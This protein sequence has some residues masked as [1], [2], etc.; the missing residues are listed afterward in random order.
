MSLH[1]SKGHYTSIVAFSTP[2]GRLHIGHA[3]GQVAAD[4]TSRFATLQGQEA[5]FPFGIHATGKDLIRI[6]SEIGNE[7]TAQKARERYELNDDAAQYVLAGNTEDDRIDRLVDHFRKSYQT[8]LGHLGIPIDQE[9]FFS[10]HDPRYHKFTQWTLRKLQEKGL[11]VQTSS[12]RPY[13]GMCDDIKAI[14]HDFSEVFPSG[15]VDLD[16]VR[17]QEGSLLL[18]DDGQ[19]KIPV[20]TTRPETIFGATN[21]F[22]NPKR[23]Y[24]KA[25]I[26]NRDVVVEESGLDDVAAALGTYRDIAVKSAE[27]SLEGKLVL[28]PTTKE[29]IPLLPADFVKSDVGSGFVMSVPAHDPFDYFYLHSTTPALLAKAKP[30]IVDNNGTP[31]SF[32]TEH[33]NADIL[34]QVRKQTY[35]LQEEGIMACTT[36][37]NGLAVPAARDQLVSN[38]IAAD[39]AARFFKI[40]GGTFYCRTHPQTRITVKQTGDT[41]INYGNEE[42]QSKTIALSQGMKV[43]PHEYKNEIPEI[44]RSRRAKPCERKREGNVGTPSPFNPDRRIEALSDSNIY[45]EYYALAKALH[46]GILSE[47]HLQDAL[48]DFLYLDKGDAMEVARSINLPLPQLKEISSMLK[49]RYPIDLNVAGLEHKDV[50]FPFS[51]FT[52]A[53]ILPEALFPKEYLLTSHVTL[54]GEK[55]SKS[56]GNVLYIDDLISKMKSQYRIPGVSE[57]ASLDAIRFFLMSYQSLENDFDWADETFKTAGVNR[58]KRYVEFVRTKVPHTSTEFTV[59]T[60]T[61]RWFMTRLQRAIATTT[62]HMQSRRFRNATIDAFD[63]FTKTIHTYMQQG[64]NEPLVSSAVQQ[65]L[66][67]MY[68]FMP[69]LTT[70]LHN[71][72]FGADITN[73]PEYKPEYEFAEEHDMIEHSFAGQQFVKSLIATV[74]R[75]V[76]TLRGMKVLNNHDTLEIVAPSHYT[77]NL[78]QTQSIKGLDLFELQFDV[79]THAKEIYMRHAGNR[80]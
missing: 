25:R 66:Q 44:I 79:D 69:R 28:N 56:K 24:L 2:S 15:K 47:E 59:A 35:Q 68:P 11:I 80:I 31:I 14:E 40:V 57:E 16:N 76:G 21:L 73:W 5:Y 6:L 61:D 12:P 19:E 8:V 41:S 23:R 29:R 38:M 60:P 39:S 26:G 42:Y 70:E 58:I 7:K 52:H 78:L 49:S 65:Q 45:M 53:A 13:C 50:H 48:F 71:D 27:I 72:A 63:V 9:S 18:F 1:L 34:E 22:F 17:V 77:A 74:N 46:Q 37:F 32:D 30:V 4:V 43:F 64:S 10:T 54:N 3:L 20:Y 33:L 51:M 67:M 75:K 55:M 36:E 62:Q